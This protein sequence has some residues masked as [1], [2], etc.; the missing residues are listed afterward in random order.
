MPDRRRLFSRAALLAALLWPG[1]A[2]SESNIVTSPAAAISAQ[3]RID[4]L[5]RIPKVLFLRVGSGA[6]MASSPTVD[7]ITFMV[8]GTNLGDGTPV[9]AT[10]GSGDL[11]SGSVTAKVFGNHGDIGFSVA[12]TGP[13][14]NGLGDFISYSE[15]DV[16]AVPL[17]TAAALPH[18]P[19]VDGGVS[20]ITLPATAKV[21]NLDASWTYTYANSAIV[22]AGDYGGA[23]INNGRITYTASMP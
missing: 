3:A 21:V 10:A 8:P 17:T 1:L 5:V 19:F 14:S 22:A 13:L 7:L 16:A 23:N 9:A 11:G 12:T 2:L 15:I 18:P 4:L 6:D 20:T